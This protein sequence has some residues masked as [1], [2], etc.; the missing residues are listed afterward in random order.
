MHLK[1]WIDAQELL[2]AAITTP[3]FHNSKSIIRA[4]HYFIL[5][6]TYLSLNNNNDAKINYEKALFLDVTLFDAFKDI[7]KNHL[8]TSKQGT[9]HIIIK[10][11]IFTV[12]STLIN[13]LP[14]ASQLGQEQA[15]FYILM[16]KSQ[17]HQVSNLTY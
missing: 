7:I 9:K 15:E 3:E 11:F 1:R 14:F 16:Y 6:Q 12:E 8:M 5:G 17:V 10:I 2:L 13:T 4:T